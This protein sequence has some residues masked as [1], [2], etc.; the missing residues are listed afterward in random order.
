MQKKN[1]SSKQKSSTMALPHSTKC[2][3]IPIQLDSVYKGVSQTP[4]KVPPAH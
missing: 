1:V 3:K 2:Y 4:K